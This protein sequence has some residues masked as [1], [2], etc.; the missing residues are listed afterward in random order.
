VPT[1]S[2]TV[3][4]TDRGRLC[5]KCGWPERDCRCSSNL[6]QGV[7]AKIVVV[8]RIEK[9]GR[10]GKSVT[11]IDE[12]P[13][14]RELVTSLAGE[15]KKALGTGGTAGETRVEIQGEHRDAIRARLQAKGWR[16][17]G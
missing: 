12:L 6:E 15:L 16:V 7:P 2:K 14:N 10:G 17:K 4:S 9:A 5:P 3:Y 8:L 13:R 11:V 1:A